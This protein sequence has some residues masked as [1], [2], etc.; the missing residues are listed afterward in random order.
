MQTRTDYYL[1]QILGCEPYYLSGGTAYT[2]NLGPVYAIII[3]TNTTFTALTY[4]DGENNII[5]CLNSNTWNFGGKVIPVTCPP[6]VVPVK[7]DRQS[8][9]VS[10]CT[11]QGEDLILLRMQR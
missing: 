2:E 3:L 4:R 5:D 1:R 10:I 7:K 11:Q 6:I 8:R 9:F